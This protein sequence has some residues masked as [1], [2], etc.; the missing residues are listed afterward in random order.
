MIQVL[1]PE[2]QPDY[3][4]H[5]PSYITMNMSTMKFSSAISVIGEV[6]ANVTKNQR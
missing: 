2:F 3:I 5:I 1:I 4:S 6:T